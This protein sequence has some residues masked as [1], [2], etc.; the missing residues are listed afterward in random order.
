MQRSVNGQAAQDD[1]W[2]GVRHVAAKPT[3]NLRRGNSARS[4]CVVSD[5]PRLITNH[6][7]ARGTVADRNDVVTSCPV[8]LSMRSSI[9]TTRNKQSAQTGGQTPESFLA[10][11][12]SEFEPASAIHH[13]TPGHGRF[14]SFI[15]ASKSPSHVG[16]WA[17][18]RLG[19]AASRDIHHNGRRHD[20][21]VRV[22]VFPDRW[23][24]G[25]VTYGLHERP[26]SGFTEAFLFK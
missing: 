3:C 13:H 18:R 4:Q 10:C 22:V 15:F 2:N 25:H 23:W 12:K 26:R 1:D 20:T 14:P 9:F 6:V 24:L 5:N 8:S 7:R 21:S 11:C 16:L 19:L 17:L